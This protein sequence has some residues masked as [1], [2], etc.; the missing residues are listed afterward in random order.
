[1]GIHHHF[2]VLRTPL[3]RAG[4]LGVA[5]F[6]LAGF[7]GL[8]G[9][10]K[11]PKLREIPLEVATD[12][13]NPRVYLEIQIGKGKPQRV[14]LELFAN[15]L[16]KTCE[17]FRALC[18]GEK[19]G[20]TYNNSIFHRI[21]P[22]FMAQGGDF[23]N[24]NGT[25]GKSIYGNRFEDEWCLETL[26][27]GKRTGKFISHSKAG[28]LSMANSGP[29][30]NGSQFFITFFAQRALDCK[31]VVFG[32]VEE[33]MDVIKAMEAVGSASGRTT[34]GVKIVDCGQLKTKSN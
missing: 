5:F 25:G 17:N 22:S 33:G 18:T 14:V 15:K 13:K 6:M 10:Y 32:Q 9:E 24:H 27:D 19:E 26:E 21:I 12:D 30:T 4:F 1:M 20:L 28:M 29:N 16:P 34:Q 2:W 11:R 31:H 3:Q 8:D 7:S 23:T